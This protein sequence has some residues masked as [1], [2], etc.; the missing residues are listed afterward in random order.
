MS[1][2]CIKFTVYVLKLT[3]GSYYVGSTSKTVAERVQEHQIKRPGSRLIDS[4]KW[5]TTR[6]AAERIERKVAAALKRSGK[7][8][9]QS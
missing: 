6:E 7:T 5:C 9:K 2:S 8:V 3:D 1:K 4:V